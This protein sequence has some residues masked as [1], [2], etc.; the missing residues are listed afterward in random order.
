[1]KE[2]EGFLDGGSTPPIS[3]SKQTKAWTYT[4]RMFYPELPRMLCAK[5]RVSLLTNGDVMAST[6]KDIQLD[7]Q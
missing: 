7:N 2:R 1:M 6:G 5:I 3:T 4:E